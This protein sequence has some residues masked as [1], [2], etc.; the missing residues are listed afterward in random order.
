MRMV[1]IEEPIIKIPQ[2]PE[3]LT[4]EDVERRLQQQYAFARR[5]KGNYGDVLAL[6]NIA[7]KLAMDKRRCIIQSQRQL[8]V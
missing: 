7:T 8:K 6:F 4:A 3:N 5:G 1:T 2:L